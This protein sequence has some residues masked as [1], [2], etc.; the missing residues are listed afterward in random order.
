VGIDLDDVRA[1]LLAERESTLRRIESLTGDFQDVVDATTGVATDDEHDPEGATIA[2]E[3]A[4]VTTLIDDARRR[5]VD[6]DRAINGL[7]DG[8]YLSCASCGCPIGEARLAAL[9]WVRR[10]VRCAAGRR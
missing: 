5:L 4:R 3:R 7:V 6:I 9:P 1:R 8:D 2:F 10:C